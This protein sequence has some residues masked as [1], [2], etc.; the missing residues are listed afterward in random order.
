M[1]HN[2]KL[3]ESIKIYVY[4]DGACINNGLINAKAGIGVFFGINDPRNV[5]QGILGKQTNN[6]AELKAIIRALEITL[7]CL[8][9]VIIYTDSEYS[10]KGINGANKIKK[11]SELFNRIFTLLKLRKGKTK[12]IKVKGHS[13]KKDGN[14]FA[15][16]LASNS[17]K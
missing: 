1:N 16:L 3:V 7:N 14:Y 10:L 4:T 8:E 11:N 17:I 9:G 12:I 13:G 2:Q 15:D 5:S 6:I